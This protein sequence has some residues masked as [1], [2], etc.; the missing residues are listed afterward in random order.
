MAALIEAVNEWEC[1]MWPMQYVLTG[2]WTR[3][4]GEC[5][6]WR[7][8]LLEHIDRWVREYAARKKEAG[9]SGADGN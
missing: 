4:E 5:L 2:G 1:V 3:S 7:G 6:E 9:S 8:D